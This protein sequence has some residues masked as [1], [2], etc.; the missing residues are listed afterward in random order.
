MRATLLPPPNP[1]DSHRP[2]FLIGWALVA[3]TFN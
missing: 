1:S 2:S 3:T